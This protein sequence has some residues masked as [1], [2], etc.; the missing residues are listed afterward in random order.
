MKQASLKQ[1]VLIAADSHRDL[2]GNVFGN[3][4]VHRWSGN[5]I[6]NSSEL[7]QFIGKVMQNPPSQW[8]LWS[9]SATSYGA[10]QGP[11]DI[12][13]ELDDWFDPDK[14]DWAQRC[15][16]IN[17]DFIEE[18]RIVDFCHTVNM[19]KARQRTS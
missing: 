6:T 14:S 4:V 11:V 8:G 17:V 16:I 2:D 9:L 10:L 5:G 7:H 3:S 12:H 18:S 15:N 19:N 1:R 13:A